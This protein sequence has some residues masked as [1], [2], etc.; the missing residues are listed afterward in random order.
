MLQIVRKVAF[1]LGWKSLEIVLILS[2]VVDEVV[3]E[4]LRCA[5]LSGGTIPQNK[6]ETYHTIILSLDTLL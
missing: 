2:Y 6:L 4:N 1:T 3:Q 5:D